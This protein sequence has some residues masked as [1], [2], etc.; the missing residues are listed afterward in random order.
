MRAAGS[1]IRLMMT[2]D[3][4]GG[5]WTYSTTLARSLGSSGFEVLLVTLGPSP[6][7]AQKAAV[8]GCQGV[9]V[10]ETDLEL[11]WQDPAGADLGHAAVELRGIAD[12]FGP[13]LI[14]LNSFREAT[15]DW[16]VP[17]VVVAHSCVNSWAEACGETDAFTGEEWNVYSRCVRAGLRDADVWV[18]PTRAFRDQ[19]VSLYRLDQGGT[20]IWNG[21]DI[22]Q[23][24]RAGKQPVVLGAGRVWDQAKNVSVLSSAATSADWPIRIAG[25]SR[26]DRST[27]AERA[28]DCQFLGEISH[29]ALLHQMDSA[30]IF[31]S[32]ALY[33]PFGLS[34]LE[35]ASAGCALMLSD[36]AT[37]RELWDGA[38]LFFDPRDRDGFVSR[39][40]SLCRDD[41]ER[42]RLQ[43]A[44]AKRAQ[45]YRLH[46]AVSDY[47][48]LYAS[49][50]AGVAGPA[51]GAH[52]GEMLA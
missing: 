30:S 26:P 28:G 2:T 49:L 12:R 16:S 3:A 7:S 27:I 40:R 31:V 33:E 13:D 48:G 29:R 46:T 44:A 20:V 22:P 47:R 42:V 50:L 52:C 51:T 41:L 11:E 6:T 8:H 43:R 32:P 37:F 35:A 10:I 24:K 39:L 18:A 14:H 23:N 45:H 4:V 15:F 38:A 25:A 19:L 9:S 5:V 1:G 34:V 21:V 36:I 17:K